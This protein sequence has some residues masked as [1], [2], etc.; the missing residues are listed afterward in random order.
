MSEIWGGEEEREAEM[1]KPRERKRGRMI[2][3]YRM[4]ERGGGKK[5][6]ENE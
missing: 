6:T 3:R 1:E 4:I 2:A 5:Q